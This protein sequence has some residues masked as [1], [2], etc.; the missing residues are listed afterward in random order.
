MTTTTQAMLI[1]FVIQKD[2]TGGDVENELS[3]RFQK[4]VV[5]SICNISDKKQKGQ[6]KL[7][8]EDTR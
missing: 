3:L 4:E 1:R 5:N 8:V 2:D 6:T 7:V